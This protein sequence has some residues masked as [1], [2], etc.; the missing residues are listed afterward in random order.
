MSEMSGLTP[1]GQPPM[2]T[3]RRATG[4]WRLPSIEAIKSRFFWPFDNPLTRSIP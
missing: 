2:P 4:G 3:I 1:A